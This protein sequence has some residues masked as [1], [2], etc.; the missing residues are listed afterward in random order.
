MEG[1]FLYFTKRI[2]SFLK[3]STSDSFNQKIP[4]EQ[5]VAEYRSLFRLLLHLPLDDNQAVSF[6]G[7]TFLQLS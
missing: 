6:D 4:I 1:V 7:D 5:L 3:S 2:D